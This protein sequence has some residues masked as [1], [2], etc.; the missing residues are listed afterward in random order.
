MTEEWLGLP[1]GEARLLASGDLGGCSIM[2]L[3]TAPNEGPPS[4]IHSRE[5]E[6]FVVL[7]GT[8]RF[9]VADREIDAQAGSFVLGPRGRP[10]TY[11]AGATGGH[12]IIV[13]APGVSNDSSR[14]GLPLSLTGRLV[15]DS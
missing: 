2:E 9:N 7:D 1:G 4:H 12:L 3:T 13:L 15:M 11:R 5:D 8:Y 6:G 10:H 14:S